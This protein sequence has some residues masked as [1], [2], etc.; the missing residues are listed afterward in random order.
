MVGGSARLARIAAERPKQSY[1]VLCL[2]YEVLV[3][4]RMGAA[5]AMKSAKHV[6]STLFPQ[7]SRKHERPHERDLLLI[8]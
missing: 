8:W 3:K 7:A 6:E 4:F 1:Y 2:H 5:T